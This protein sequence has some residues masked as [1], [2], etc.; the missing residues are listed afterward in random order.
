M[1]ELALHLLDL[2]EN[3]VAAGARAVT[4]VVV[5]DPAADRLSLTIRDDGRG[6]DADLVARVSDPFVTSRTERRVGLGVPLLK[7]AAEACAGGLSVQ[8]APGRGT[9]VQA[10]FQRSHLDRMPLGDLAGTWL[11]LLVGHPQ[12]HWRF[13]YQ[14][15]PETFEFD[16]APVKQTLAGLPLTEPAVLHYLRALL[17]EGVAQAAGAAALPVGGD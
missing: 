2:A 12:V 5:E 17:A 3:S 7:A 1:R 15:G 4:I 8:S 11:T 13:A 10:D 14:V 16:D 6:M 9:Q